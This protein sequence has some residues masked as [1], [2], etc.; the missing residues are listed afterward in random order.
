MA[1]LELGIELNGLTVANNGLKDL[2][3]TLS[4]MKAVKIDVGV[5]AL[6]EAKVKAI[7]ANTAIKEMVA[8]ANMGNAKF[9]TDLKGEGLKAKTEL[10][11]VTTE[12]KKVESASK[13]DI[14]KGISDAR[15]ETEKSRKALIDYNLEQKKLRDASKKPLD[16]IVAGE[17][18]IVKMRQRLNELRKIYDNLSE[19]ARNSARVQNNLATEINRI[20]QAV[21][22][23]EQATGR[24]Q[25]NVGNYSSAL[26][27]AS[28]VAMEFNRIIQDAPFG[29]VG[30]GNNIQ[31]LAANWQAYTQQ[32]RAAAQANGTTVTSMS[33]VRGALSSIISPANLLTLGIAAVTSAWTYYSMNTK[34]ASDV[35]DDL[36]NQF[37]QQL[38]QLRNIISL[39]ERSAKTERDKATAVSMYNKELG[40]TFGKVKSYAEL[41][42][43]IIKNGGAYVQ[44]LTLKAKAEAAY[45][46]SIKNTISLL[47]KQQK[48]ESG[49]LAW[50]EKVA[51]KAEGFINNTI[52][53][54]N[55][56]TSVGDKDFA[57]LMGLPTIE[58]AK[59]YTSK[60]V[61]TLQNILIN[62]WKDNA[63][64]EGFADLGSELTQQFNKIA[65]AIGN[66]PM[67]DL[68]L[69]KDKNSPKKAGELVDYLQKIKDLLSDKQKDLDLINVDGQARDLKE[70]EWKYKE[71]FSELDKLEKKYRADKNKNKQSGVLEGIDSARK[72]GTNLQTKERLEI[73]KKWLDERIRLT[74]EANNK[75]GF[76]TENSREKDL[77]NLKI[78][79]EKYQ[80]EMLKA[81]ATI[82]EVTEKI[83]SLNT[84]ATFKINVEF[85]KKELD[86]FDAE[87]DK[88]AESINKPFSLKSRQK[89]QDELRKR[90]F[91]LRQSL[92]RQSELARSLFGASAGT[93]EQIEE[94]VSRAKV[95]WQIEIDENSKTLF[96][97]FL[98]NTISSAYNDLFQNMKSNV[99]QFGSTFRALFYSIGETIQGAINNINTESINNLFE[100]IKTSGWQSASAMEKAAAGLATA[101]NLISS[102]TSKSSVAGQGI[103]G[104]LSGAGAGLG[105]GNML[106]DTLGKSAGIWGAAIGGVVGLIGGI[107]GAKKK[108]KEE[109]R[110]R[111]QLEEQKKTNA[112]LERMNALAY[113]SQIIGG[114]TTNGIVTGVNRNEFGEITIRIEGRDLVGSFNRTNNLSRR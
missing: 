31:Q 47:Q 46:L 23:A 66:I 50:Y 97:N 71:F 53:G 29:M 3:K 76:V 22:Q 99:E 14:A 65:D 41:E 81:G 93:K 9:L 83:A 58:E 78:Y 69:D 36:N 30:I 113:T 33:L 104:A 5:S 102:M 54:K 72:T 90:E 32:A 103:G 35:T 37:S 101:G 67:P 87:N 10:I 8:T 63:K 111:Q 96:R 56:S 88:I 18:S 16:N 20:N 106:K 84:T 82:E 77:K 68:G 19:S 89:M 52:G 75:W 51:V 91:E 11:G 70:L 12:L 92:E 49:Q 34:K 59:K 13:I 109:E 60:Y 86:A 107:F 108:R 110:Q 26:G 7:E 25:R 112:L 57:Y 64:A 38:G 95:Q 94:I 80:Q 1:I 43:N 114:K 24:F 21:S 40:D 28:G 74:E 4:S 79:L 100:K 39:T 44:Y 42:K 17:G 105:I 73:E 98:V 6:N 61:P 15:I 45:Q 85:Y 62:A 2:Q 55:L 27:D 48:L